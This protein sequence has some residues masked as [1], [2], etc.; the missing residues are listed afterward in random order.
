MPFNHRKLTVCFTKKRPA[1]APGVITGGTEVMVT[2][3]T[4]CHPNNFN[5][6][7]VNSMISVVRM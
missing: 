2:V 3:I 4:Y 5:P 1:L 6:F 7:D